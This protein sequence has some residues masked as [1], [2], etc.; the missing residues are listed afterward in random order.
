MQETQ[1]A[2]G[3]WGT[4]LSGAYA[5][6]EN[7][8]SIKQWQTSKRLLVQVG[9]LTW[10]VCSTAKAPMSSTTDWNR[11]DAILNLVNREDCIFP[12]S[13]FERILAVYDEIEWDYFGL[14]GCPLPLV[15]D[16]MRLAR[17]GASKRKFSSEQSP[18]FDESMILEIQRSLESWQYVSRITTNDEESMQGDQD[19]MHCSEAWRNGLLLYIYRVF[20]WRAGDKTP[21]QVLFRARAIAD[22]VFA[23]R[24]DNM[25]TRQALLP[26]FFAGCELRDASTRRKIIQ[27][28]KMWEDKTRYHMFNTTVPL[29][30]QIWA[31]QEENGFENVWWGQVVDSQQTAGPEGLLQRRLCFG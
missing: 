28:C 15:K 26:L 9:M 7:C 13:Y 1:S 17:L 23:S 25:I 20:H 14:C 21:L 2:F 10:Y 6:L 16:V 30:Q 29:L 22:R 3:T 4:H 11:W 27:H 19:R 18:Q 12:I 31:E 24:E 5:L 8:H